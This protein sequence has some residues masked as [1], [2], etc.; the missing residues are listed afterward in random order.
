MCRFECSLVVVLRYCQAIKQLDE[1]IKAKIVF[2]KEASDCS[3]NW[4][5]N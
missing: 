1:D 2:A 5:T 3:R 4:E